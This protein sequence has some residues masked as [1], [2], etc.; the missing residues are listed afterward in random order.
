MLI[1][2]SD[3]HANRMLEYND[4]SNG[5]IK[6]QEHRSLCPIFPHLMSGYKTASTEHFVTDT[7]RPLA[8]IT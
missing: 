1:R 8:Y 2:I 4:R 6:A 7:S 3:G 5:D